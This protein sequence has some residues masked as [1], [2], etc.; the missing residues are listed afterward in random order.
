[1]PIYGRRYDQPPAPT[2][3]VS[4]WA[5]L[6][7][8][9]V[10]AGGGRQPVSIGDGAW[11]IEVTGEDNG[12]SVRELGALVDFV[13]PHVYRMDS[14]Q[15]RQHLNAAFLCELAAVGGRPV[16]PEEFGVSTD[17][18]SAAGAAS[19]YRQTCTTRCWPGRPAGSPGT[20]PTTTI[21]PI[22]IPTGTTRSRCTSGSPTAPARSSRRCR[23]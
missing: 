16:V 11:G 14:D 19:Y 13:G 2:R 15:L 20:T 21:W 5:Q 22:R 12:F 9:A 18:A 10:R 8:H 4:A 7:V 17:F 1:M 23:S 3:Q 6:M